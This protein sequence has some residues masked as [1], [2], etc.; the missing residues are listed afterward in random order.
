[1]FNKKISFVL[2]LGLLCL[3]LWACGGGSAHEPAETYV[4]SEIEQ[5]ELP[6]QSVMA[7]T[8]AITQPMETESEVP[9]LTPIDIE[10]IGGVVIIGEIGRD[11]QGWYI[12]P[13]QPLNVTYKYFLDK[14]SVF[15]EQ[16]RIS[17]FD[18]K[19]DGF[20]KALYIGQTITAYGTFRF[21]RDD[22]ETLYFSPYEVIIGKNAE[23][24]YAAPELKGQTE[25]ENLFDPSKPLPKEMD[26]KIENGKYVYNE[27][28]L[29]EE[30]LEYMGNDYASF[31]VDFVSAFFE[32][33]TE[34]K[35]PDKQYAEMLSTIIYYE[36]PIYNACAQPFE[37]F[38]HYNAEKGV[39]SIVYTCDE[40]KHKEIVDKFFNAANS[41]LADV[42]VGQTDEEKAK[43]IYHAICTRMTYDYSALVDF[44]RKENYYAYLN[45]SGVCTTFANVYNQLLTRVGIKA[46]LAHCD[47]V[48]TIGHSWS[49]VTIDGKQYFCDPT[50]EL[51]YDNGNGY[52]FFGMNYADRTADGLGAMGIRYRR[53]NLRQLDSSM[54]SA[55]SLK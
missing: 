12:K 21:Y 19:V 20:E 8:Q 1:M 54:I 14:P 25:P 32:Y 23:K 50:Y 31:Y 2:L 6:A 3:C 27:F 15:A 24:S 35:C 48:D 52:I 22:F 51:S 55:E 40:K 9:V 53:Y 43:S 17:M 11:E 28:M 49:L 26:I 44:E 42:S 36:L 37:F 5:S 41:M 18:P 47:N 45:N 7:D 30:T 34:V 10:T 16:I 38:K 33:K 13:E 4:E 46:T 39:V 29:S